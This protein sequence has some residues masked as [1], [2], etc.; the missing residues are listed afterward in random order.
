MQDPNKQYPAPTF[1]EQQQAGPGL[2]QK[3]DPVTDHGE[4]SYRRAGRLQG[5]RH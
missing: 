5:A 3:M 2:A 4:S 1:E